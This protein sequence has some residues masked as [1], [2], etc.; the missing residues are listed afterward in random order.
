VPGPIVPGTPLYRFVEMV[1]G[2]M[3]E[4]RTDRAPWRGRSAS[5]DSPPPADP[6]P[7][8]PEGDDVS[9]ADGG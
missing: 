2:R 8:D 1:A 3:I 5:V 6:F 4:R 7:A 9:G